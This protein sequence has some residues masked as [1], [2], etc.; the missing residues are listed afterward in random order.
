[1]PKGEN[2]KGKGG[3]KFGSGQPTNRGGR[4]PNLLN[5]LEK[6]IGHDFNVE[7]SKDDKFRILESMCEMSIKQLKNIATDDNSPAF[8]VNIATAIHADIKKG[9]IYTLNGLFD[10]FFG[11]AIKKSEITGAN[12][13]A[14]Q[15]ESKVDWSK[16]SV[17]QLREITKAIKPAD[18]PFKSKK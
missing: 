16:L 1:M 6:K 14:I 12:G 4:K 7:L 18:E 2:L 15:T 5:S 8:M 17:E 10:R 9:R 13:G 3:V 11:K